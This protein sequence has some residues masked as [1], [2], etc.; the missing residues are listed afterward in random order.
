MF[1]MT[2]KNLYS[3][4]CGT[5]FP[6]SYSRNLRPSELNSTMHA[7]KTVLTADMLNAV[8]WRC[9]QQFVFYIS[10]GHLDTVTAILSINESNFPL[11]SAVLCP[12][13]L[14]SGK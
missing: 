1:D 9:P 8:A 6:A 4:S 14:C 5:K 2:A 3:A 11:Y 10:V 12:K 7:T 13:R